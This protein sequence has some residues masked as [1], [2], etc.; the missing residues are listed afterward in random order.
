MIEDTD[1]ALYFSVAALWEVVIKGSLNRAD[2]VVDPALLRRGLVNNGYFEL[3][4]DGNHVL[5]VT[6]LPDIHRDPFDRI[7]IAQARVD[8]FQFL[9]ADSAVAAYGDPVRKV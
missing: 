3:P 8:G 1:N 7:Q 6:G 9:T 4:I 5:A 2:F